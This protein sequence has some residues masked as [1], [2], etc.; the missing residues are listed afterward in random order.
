M[1]GPETVKHLVETELKCIKMIPRYDKRRL[2]ELTK[3]F[4]GM[5]LYFR[6]RDFNNKSDEQTSARIDKKLFEK[7]FQ[8]QDESVLSEMSELEIPEF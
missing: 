8:G 3:Q 1:L 4:T 7:Y 6:L 2:L 5:E